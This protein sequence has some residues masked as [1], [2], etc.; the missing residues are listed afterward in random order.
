TGRDSA[1]L[2][3]HFEGFPKTYAG[4]AVS[5]F[6]NLFFGAGPGSG[7]NST[8]VTEIYES[9]CANLLDIISYCESNNIKS[10]EVKHEE[11]E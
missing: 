1:D 8:S 9:N 7:T 10:I 3:N 11:V 6:P 5:S 2:N 4:S